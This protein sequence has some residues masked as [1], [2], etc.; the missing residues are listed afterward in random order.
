MRTIQ[1]KTINLAN[2]ASG[3]LFI[4]KAEGDTLY[5]QVEGSASISVKG[6]NS[7]IDAYVMV[8]AINM[9]TF[10]K[11]DNITEE[12]FYMCVIGGLDQIE[13]EASGSG[14]M[15]WKVMGD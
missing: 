13:M 12:G 3:D 5:I 8:P 15:H 6:K 7:E 11:S 10:A 9:S 4:K 14:K 2:I 1:E